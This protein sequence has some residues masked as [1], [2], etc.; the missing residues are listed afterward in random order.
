MEYDQQM[1]QSHTTDQPWHREEE[2]KN[3]NIH[4]KSEATNLRLAQIMVLVPR[5]PLVWE[6]VHVIHM[7]T[8]GKHALISLLSMK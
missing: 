2:S 8:L 7:L 5:W 3:G 4:N 1:P 6:G